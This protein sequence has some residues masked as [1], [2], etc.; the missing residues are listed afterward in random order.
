MKKSLLIIIALL[1]SIPVSAQLKIQ[2]VYDGPNAGGTPKGVELFVN[3]D[4]ADLSVY[5]ISSANNGTGTTAPVPEFV[6]PAV[7]VTAG[8]Y[9]YVASEATEF[10]NFF[11]FP[12]DYTTGA[13]A[14]NGDDAIELFQGAV[15]IDVFG[16]VDTDGTGQ[17]WEYLD[18]WVY[19]TAGTGPDGITFVLGNWTFSG[20]NQLEGGATN[21]TTTSP[22]PIGTLPVELQNFSV[23]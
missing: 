23:E 6:F 4:I 17:P 19:R 8:T 9:I 13:M 3:S 7:A 18:G 22:F 20:I 2:G 1:L 5:G 11:G 14:I 12:P 16:D 10:N 15:V 21:G